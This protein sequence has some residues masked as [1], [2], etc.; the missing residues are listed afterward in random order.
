M[1]ATPSTRCVLPAEWAPHAATWLTW[2][3]IAEDWGGKHAAVC[4][5]WVA[6]ARALR[7]GE[8]VRL[9]VD[10]A[11]SPQTIESAFDGD[12]KGVDIVPMV[13]DDVW[14]RDYGPLFVDCENGSCRRWAVSWDFNAW[15]RKYPDWAK[16]AAVSERAARHV[17]VPN[18]EPG[19]VLE[20]GAVEVDG[21][22]SLLATERSVVDPARNPEL[23]RT[24][25][26]SALAR[27]LG[28]RRIIWLGGMLE[29]DDTDGHIDT[30]TRFVKPAL[31]VTSIA[32]D[33]RDPNRG[34]LEKNRELLRTSQ[35]A[36]G[37]RLEVVDLPLPEP[38][39]LGGRR[40]P[41]SYAN[42]YIGNHVVLVPQYRSS[43]DARAL[44]ILKDL[45]PERNVVGI[46]CVEILQGGGA[47][48]CLTLQQPL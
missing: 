28:A 37:R 29:G 4:R 19:I 30:L 32:A 23:D 20:G 48:H 41:A 15:G 1:S 31:V 43:G 42:F 14:I 40:L 22:G 2:P 36:S 47:L 38:V 13:T 9:V 12:L 39:V 21:E 5:A 6:I 17:D 46:D 44:G 27:W 18:V 3:G 7:G 8:R 11:I 33:R 26:E 10:P 24:A 34:F 45:F 25:M 16:D 35:D